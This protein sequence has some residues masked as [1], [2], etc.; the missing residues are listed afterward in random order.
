MRYGRFDLEQWKTTK[1]SRTK[2]L[3]AIIVLSLLSTALWVLHIIY[4]IPNLDRL[5]IY[6]TALAVFQIPIFYLKHILKASDSQALQWYESPILYL[7]PIFIFVL[8]F[9]FYVQI[10]YNKAVLSP[11]ARTA[12]PLALY[13]SPKPRRQRIYCQCPNLGHGVNLSSCVV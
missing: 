4:D 5:A 13:V 12:M 2:H 8:C 10:I 6:P 7:A 1:A 3:L 11:A 9:M